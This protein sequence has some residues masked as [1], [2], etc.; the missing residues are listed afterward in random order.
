VLLPPQRPPGHLLDAR[1][2]PVRSSGSREVY[3]DDGGTNNS[4]IRALSGLRALGGSPR[5]IDHD[6]LAM[7]DSR[8]DLSSVLDE[9]PKVLRWDG[10]EVQPSD[11]RKKFHIE[12]EFKVIG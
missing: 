11:E 1:G 3:G 8:V 7:L 5:P 4:G 9:L 6:K 12:V 2:K 10:A